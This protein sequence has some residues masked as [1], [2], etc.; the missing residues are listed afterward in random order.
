MTVCVP[1]VNICEQCPNFHSDAGS[2]SVV[3]AQ[4][5]DHEALA[6]DAEAR[7]WLDEAARHRRLVA[8]LD[9]LLSATPSA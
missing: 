2:I 9:A 4:R 1:Q 5:V 7:G 6:A 8:R 3:G